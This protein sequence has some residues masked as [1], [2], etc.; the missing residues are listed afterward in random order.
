MPH[1]YSKNIQH[2]VFSTKNREKLI[3]K[4]LQPKLWA[5]SAGICRN[6]GI[7]PVEI[8]GIDNH[9]H[10]LIQIPAA[11]SLA[12]AVSTIKSNSSRWISEQKTSFAWQEGYAAFSVSASASDTV[13][14]YIKNQESHH[15]KMNFEEELLALLKKH[16]VDFDAQHIFG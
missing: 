15:R 1:S 9:I 5:Y 4:S 11:M 12:K 13:V 10:L 2:I 16:N 3:P 7:I 6:H 14:R 8:G